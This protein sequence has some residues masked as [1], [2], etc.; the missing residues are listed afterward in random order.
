MEGIEEDFV[1]LLFCDYKVKMDKVLNLD[2]V[3]MIYVIIYEASFTNLV[4][5]FSLPF[6]YYLNL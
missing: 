3:G 6:S 5:N 4:N 1:F 2:E